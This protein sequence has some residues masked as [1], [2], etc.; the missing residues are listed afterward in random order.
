MHPR[1]HSA[2]LRSIIPSNDTRQSASSLR[3]RTRKMLRIFCTRASL[4]RKSRNSEQR[5]FFVPPSR[6]VPKAPLAVNM[7]SVW[8]ETRALERTDHR[9]YVTLNGCRR[10]RV[11]YFCE[12]RIALNM[13]HSIP[14]H[15]H[16]SSLVDVLVCSS[17][18]DSK[19]TYIQRTR[20]KN[21]A[22]RLIFLQV[23][24]ACSAPPKPSPIASEHRAIS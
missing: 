8:S 4:S 5:H 7:I 12:T 21:A 16:S 17:Q 6:S 11:Q 18:R 23:C 14:S 10:I 19:P 2:L 9:S 20:R 13:Q 15:Y 1:A 3:T 24:C 22:N